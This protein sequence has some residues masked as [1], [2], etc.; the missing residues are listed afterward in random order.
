MGLVD[1]YCEP[2][3]MLES[4]GPPVRVQSIEDRLPCERGMVHREIEDPPRVVPS[5][6]QMLDVLVHE[7]G[8]A[9][10]AEAHDEDDVLRP[11]PSFKLSDVSFP[12]N[13]AGLE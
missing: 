5:L 11:L 4:V 1:D 10:P 2:I 6:D 7:R 12:L 9:D 8:L 13:A 3:V